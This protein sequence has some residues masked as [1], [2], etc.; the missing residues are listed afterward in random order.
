[1]MATPGIRTTV[2]HLSRAGT[3]V[4]L[5]I[6]PV[7][8]RSELGFVSEQTTELCFRTAGN[9]RKCGDICIF[10]TGAWPL[11]E[12]QACDTD[13]VES[14][15]EIEL[16]IVHVEPTLCVHDETGAEIGVFV[17]VHGQAGKSALHGR[18][19]AGE[20]V[21]APAA[22][23][24]RVLDH[25]GTRTKGLGRHKR[26]AALTREWFRHLSATIHDF[27]YCLILHI[28]RL[29]PTWYFTPRLERIL[30]EGSKFYTKV[31]NSS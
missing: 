16:P 10:V 6:R 13:V 22:D 14:Q 28:S 20:L 8:R 29:D 26:P 2:L 4:A 5:G 24:C 12:C 3:G 27:V 1:M 21:I 30:H 17:R 23:S 19:G 9:R 15:V 18:A 7:A 11:A 25:V 31:R